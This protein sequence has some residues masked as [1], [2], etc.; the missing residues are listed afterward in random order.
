MEE[1]TI[2]FDGEDRGD[3]QYSIRSLWDRRTRVAFGSDW[4]VSSPDPLQ[5]I[6]VAVNRM[7]SANFGRPGTN[8]TTKPL[9]PDQGLS[10][11]EALTAFTQNVA[12]VNGDEDLLGS[13]EV[14]RRGDVAVLS[15]D[16]FSI[17]PTDIGYTNVDLTVGGGAVVHGDE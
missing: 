17:P 4:P 11:G 14:G 3:W 9:R 16:L 7:L 13:L 5:E 10:V 2:P 8:E 12:Y 6:H 15:Q 1:L